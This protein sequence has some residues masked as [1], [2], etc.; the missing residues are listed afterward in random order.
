MLSITNGCINGTNLPVGVALSQWVWLCVGSE[1]VICVSGCG[2][3]SVGVAPGQ[4]SI[5]CYLN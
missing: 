4:S 1:S 3:V 2:S 5:I